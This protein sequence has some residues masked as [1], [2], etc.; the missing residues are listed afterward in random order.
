MAAE[1]WSNTTDL[2]TALLLLKDGLLTYADAPLSYY[3]V[4][5]SVLENLEVAI[6]SQNLSSWIQQTE[7][8]FGDPGIAGYVTT[9]PQWALGTLCSDQNN[10]WY[11]K[12]LQDLRTPIEELEQRS[13][14][15]EIWS[16]QYLGCTGWSTKASEIYHGPFA[17]NT[18]TPILFVDNTYDPVTAIEK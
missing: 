8:I 2:E 14:I 5:P 17:G 1:H 9:N 7:T 4:L 16:H 6:S 3:R 10:F 18:T 11:N 12:T 15:G 13:I